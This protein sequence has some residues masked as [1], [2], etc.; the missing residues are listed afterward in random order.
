MRVPIR[1][2]GAEKW[3]DLSALSQTHEIC[4]EKVKC[5]NQNYSFANEHRVRLFKF[6]KNVHWRIPE[7]IELDISEIA[8][9]EPP[10]RQT[11]R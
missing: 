3:G 11:R 9:A 6:T 10:R 5:V 4:G 2:V 7:G 1:R 8:Q